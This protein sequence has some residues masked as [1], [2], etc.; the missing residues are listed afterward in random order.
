VRLAS[1]LKNAELEIFENSGHA[2]FLT[3]KEPFNKAV[4]GFL[5]KL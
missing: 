3:E 2:P 4:K 1:L 5:A